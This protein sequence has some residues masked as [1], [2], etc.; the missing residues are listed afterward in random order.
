MTRNFIG[1]SFLKDLSICD[2]LINYHKNSEEKL[3]GVVG[4]STEIKVVDK[5]IKLST[6]VNISVD[7]ACKEILFQKYFDELQIAL[8]LYIEKYPH[9]NNQSPFTIIEN[10]NIQ[11]YKA[12]EGYFAWH[13]ER[14]S[15]IMPV[16]TRHLVFMTYLNDVE[17]EGET[18]FYYQDLKVKPKK[19]KTLIWCSDWTHTHRGI[20]SPTQEKYIITG[21]FN[22]INNTI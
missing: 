4:K 17:D 19:G 3:S 16:A 14:G 18:E 12:N 22:F 13:C 9:C 2:D 6:D 10:I 8:N 5:D 7:K 1:E 11:H 20:T 21:W 15:S